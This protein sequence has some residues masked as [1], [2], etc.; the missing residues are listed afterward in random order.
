MSSCKYTV[1]EQATLIEECSMKAMEKSRTQKWDMNMVVFMFAILLITVILLYEG[2]DPI[3]LAPIAFF[4]LVMCWYTSWR[5]GKKLYRRY[6][7]QEM[8]KYFDEGEITGPEA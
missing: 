4:G 5:Q 3:Y 1:K 2:I 7:K 8:A 6:F